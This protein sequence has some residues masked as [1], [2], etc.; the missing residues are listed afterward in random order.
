M[1]ITS[2]L[3]IKTNKEN[4]VLQKFCFKRECYL[5]TRRFNQVLDRTDE[6]SR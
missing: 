3:S 6:V 2:N 1:I 5:S 4:S